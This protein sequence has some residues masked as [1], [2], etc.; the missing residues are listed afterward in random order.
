EDEVAI[1]PQQVACHWCRIH[2][3]PAEDRRSHGVKTEVERGHDAEVAA[4]TPQ[5]PEKV[6]VLV[7]RRDDLPAVGRHHLGLEEVVAREAELALEPAAPA[8]EEETADPGV[9]HTAAGHGETLLLRGGL[10][11]P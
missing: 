7:L 5:A 6:G 3:L 8:P 4:P 11:R 1:E 2:Q 9:G 10:D